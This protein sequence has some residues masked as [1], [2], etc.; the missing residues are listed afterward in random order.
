MQYAIYHICELLAKLFKTFDV[1]RDLSGLQWC[2]FLGLC[3]G[4]TPFRRLFLEREAV[5]LN[6]G[7]AVADFGHNPYDTHTPVAGS[8]S[9]GTRSV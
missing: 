5:H 7:L 4:L 6:R 8:C 2:N 3:K 9:T 1:G